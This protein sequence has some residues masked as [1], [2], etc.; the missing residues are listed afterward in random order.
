[1]PTAVRDIVDVQCA[2]LSKKTYIQICKVTRLNGKGEVLV[3]SPLFRLST[4]QLGA[5]L[6]YTDNVNN[7]NGNRPTSKIRDRR[8]YRKEHTEYGERIEEIEHA[9]P[10]PNR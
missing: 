2:R 4:H 5:C 1:M 10:M 9:L 7:V 8:R 3:T 6:P